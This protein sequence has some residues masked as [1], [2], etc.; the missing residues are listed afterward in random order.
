MTRKTNPESSTVYQVGIPSWFVTFSDVI[1]LLITFFIL[2]FTYSVTDPEEHD[3]IRASLFPESVVGKWTG[4]KTQRPPHDSFLMRIRPPVAQLSVSGME[5]PPIV[6]QA[7]W[8]TDNGYLEFLEP[9]PDTGLAHQYTIEFRYEQF[10]NPQDGLS[11]LGKIQAEMLAAKMIQVPML[12]TLEVANE[13][14]L[15]AVLG[16]ARHLVRHYDI[17][18]GQLATRVHSGLPPDRV[19]LRIEHYLDRTSAGKSP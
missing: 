18:P 7:A 8:R 6:T 1:T 17:K 14:G 13:T 2:L 15:D 9:D 5:M 10:F 19:R 4:P 16:F 3:Q 12:V 11:E